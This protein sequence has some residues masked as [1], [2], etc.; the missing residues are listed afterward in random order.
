MLKVVRLIG[1]KIPLY[2]NKRIHPYG[3]MIVTDGVTEKYVSFGYRK[4][5]RGFQLPPHRDYI[6]F[7]RKRYGFRNVGSL[8]YPK[9]EITE[10]E[11]KQ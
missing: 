9:M 2:G 4:D 3:H 11:E 6:T 8:Y 5:K 1:Y 7:N 10:Y